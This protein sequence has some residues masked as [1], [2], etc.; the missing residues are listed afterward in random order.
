MANA[1]LINKP[2]GIYVAITIYIDNT[3]K[4]SDIQEKALLGIDM[5]CETSLTLSNGEKLKLEVK[6]TERLK[7]LQRSL[8]RCKKGSNNRWRI[9]RKIRAE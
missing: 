5:G 4:H 9:R 1:K 7:R 8:A 6:E 2:D 3:E